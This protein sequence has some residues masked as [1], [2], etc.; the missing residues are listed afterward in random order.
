MTPYNAAG[1]GSTIV[2][3]NIPGA[4]RA[5]VDTEEREAALLAAL[6]VTEDD[7]A[8]P[9]VQITTRRVAPSGGNR[10]DAYGANRRRIDS[11]TAQL[12][13]AISGIYN[14]QF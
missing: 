14:V 11:A 5:D 2:A 4:T 7:D 12:Q 1:V 10:A 6:G 8:A 9:Y 13:A 3:I